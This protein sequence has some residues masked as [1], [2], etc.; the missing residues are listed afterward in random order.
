M[1]S[2][3][4]LNDPSTER[5]NF[6]ARALTLF[7]IAALL[8]VILIGRLVQLQVLEYE[9]YQ[10]RSEENRI[11]VQPLAPPRGLIKDRNGVL[12]AEN[13]PVSSLALVAERVRDLDDL[14]D[15]LRELVDLGD[16]LVHVMQAETRKF[17]D[18]ERLWTE[19]PTD[20][21]S[22]G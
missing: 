19:F 1:A 11:Q 13:R 14:L 18:L 6:V 22:R 12:L 5:R 21:E 4:S 10:T 9:T 2:S 15:E 16:V 7:L 17:Y 3:L 20:T 8:V